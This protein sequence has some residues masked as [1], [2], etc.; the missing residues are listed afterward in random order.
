MTIEAVLKGLDGIEAKLTAISTKADGELATLGKVT[1]DTKTA[2]DNIGVQQRELADRLLVLEQKGATPAA[3][4]EGS[5]S[6]GKQ[7]IKANGYQSFLGGQQQKCRVEVKNTL[8]GSDANV[9]PDRRAGI[10]PGAFNMLTIES[11]Y[12]LGC[13]SGG[14][15][16]QGGIGPHVVSGE[17]A[18]FDRRALDQDFAPTGDGQSRSGCVCGQPHALWRAA[19]G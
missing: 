14:R 18:G 2:L 12:A 5:E 10:V 8:T 17:H 19:Q 16:C 9:A 15:R 13:G 7:L 6:W 3:A 1:A 11:L 4:E